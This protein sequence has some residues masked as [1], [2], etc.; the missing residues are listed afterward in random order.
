[1]RSRRD[2]TN[3]EKVKIPLD[4]VIGIWYK[5][6]V[7]KFT[8][9]SGAGESQMAQFRAM[10]EKS[11]I[12]KCECGAE[13]GKGDCR[14]CRLI[15]FNIALDSAKSE[16]ANLDTKVTDEQVA[17]REDWTRI[18]CTYAA[19]YTGENVYLIAM[20]NFWKAN[21]SLTISQMRGILNVI[22]H[23]ARQDRKEVA[24]QQGSVT[25]VTAPDTHSV[26][27]GYFTVSFED[28]THV[29][30]RVSKSRKEGKQN[31]S[32]LC[33]PSNTSDYRYFAGLF[34]TRVYAKYGNYT[35]Q[36]AA[37]KVLMSADKETTTAFG[38]A[39]AQESGN[40]YVCGRLLTDPVSIED[41]IGPI[42]AGRQ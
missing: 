34:G 39:Y 29:T 19:V 30:I 18:A 13:C 37:L 3:S 1:V 4:R 32:Y 42:C 10:V 6:S 31:V 40:C 41:G 11:S 33:G 17:A 26:A 23:G 15:R 5:S 20:R 8:G 24:E 21:K 22:R 2:S 16:L 28:G 7:E 38:K 12:V 9:K 25:S 35:R 14:A 36:L 27:N